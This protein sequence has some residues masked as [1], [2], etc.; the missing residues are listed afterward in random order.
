MTTVTAEIENGI[1]YLNFLKFSY[2]KDFDIDVDIDERCIYKSIPA[3]ILQPVL[4][5]AFIHGINN[6]SASHQ[7]I[8]EIKAQTDDDDVIITV[9]D[10]GGKFNEQRFRQRIADETRNHAFKTIMKRMKLYYNDDKY[11]VNISGD[12]HKTVVTFRF[13]KEV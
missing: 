7:G 8:I 13:G 6:N 1:E 9:T 11:S 4:E 12:A 3:N 10:N 5:N 2:E